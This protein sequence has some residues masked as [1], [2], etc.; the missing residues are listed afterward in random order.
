MTESENGNPTRVTIRRTETVASELDNF[1]QLAKAL[2][3]VSKAEVDE[4]RA[5][6][7]ASRPARSK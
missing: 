2:V 5:Q 3:G 7:P 6:E 1:T 4:K